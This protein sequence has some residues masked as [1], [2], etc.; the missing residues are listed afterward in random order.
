VPTSPVTVPDGPLSWAG[1][2]E[3]IQKAI[4]SALGPETLQAIIS[5][6]LSRVTSS[7]AIQLFH[8]ATVIADTYDGGTHTATLQMDGD[9]P[10]PPTFAGVLVPMVLSPGERVMVWFDKPHVAYVIG[11]ATLP[12]PPIIRV[13]DLC[14]IG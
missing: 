9:P 1:V 12:H 5:H 8:P 11:L 10:D 4:V 14:G 13:S 2:N 7:T 3:L 6:V